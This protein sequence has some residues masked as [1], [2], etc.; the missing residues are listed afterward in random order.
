MRVKKIDVKKTKTKNKNKNVN[1][2]I[3]KVV[4]QTRA[5]QRKSKTPEAIT[6]EDIKKQP[7]PIKFKIQGVNERPYQME[8][9]KAEI[10][11][12]QEVRKFEI[13]QEQ[14]KERP[15]QQEQVRE[16]TDKE[17]HNE[18]VEKY[19]D[20][21]LSN[22]KDNMLPNEGGIRKIWDGEFLP[23]IY[24]EAIQEIKK[25][26]QGAIVKRGQT[27]TKRQEDDDDK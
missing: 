1:T 23:F 16:K 6:P 15:V 13:P 22:I 17:H 7:E 26:N 4:V 5:R 11:V 2:N 24:R 27:K 25:R 19:I 8:V 9:Y 14:V 20:V 3:V 10:P 21:I 18:L 12:K